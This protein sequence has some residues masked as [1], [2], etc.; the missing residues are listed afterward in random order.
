[1]NLSVALQTPEDIYNALCAIESGYNP[2]KYEIQQIKEIK[3]L[4]LTG[5]GIHE[6][7]SSVGLLSSLQILDLGMTG[8]SSIPEQIGKLISLRKL[9]LFRTK[10]SSLPSSIGN[11]QHL[12]A[13]DLSC[14][15]IEKLPESIC[16]LSALQ[17][18]D[19]SQ[20]LIKELP[21]QIG[22]LSSL[23]RL[24][25]RRTKLS[26]L[27][28]SVI[29]LPISCDVYIN[30]TC[31]ESASVE[32]LN[33][34]RIQRTPK[35]GKVKKQKAIVEKGP[36][37]NN[38]E[39]ITWL[40]LSD[41]H[42]GR[43][44]YNE[45][46]VLDK[47]LDDIQLM[48]DQEAIKLDLILI[49]GDLV[50]S[51]KKEQY[52]IADSFLKKLL[53]VAKL[54]IDDV[55]ITPGNHDVDRS[56]VS[57]NQ[58]KLAR[59]ID[60]RNKVTEIISND[61]T[62]AKYLVGLQNYYSF[63]SQFPWARDA[64][65]LPLHF[66]I[67]KNIRGTQIAVMALNTAWLAY[68]FNNEKGRL[69]LG[70]KQVRDAFEECDDSKLTI[71]LMHHP[72]SWL[73]DF[74]TNDVQNTLERR[75]DFILSGHEH[76]A[77]LTGKDYFLGRA[78]K[79]SAG[80]VY[81]DRNQLN[82]YNIIRC[83]VA[84]GEAECF[85]REYVDKNGGFWTSDNTIDK[86]ITSGK[87]TVKYRVG[88]SDIAASKHDNTKIHSNQGNTDERKAE[89]KE[90]GRY[91]AHTSDPRPSYS[92]PAPPRDLINKIRE[93]K[94]VLFAG[95]GVSMDAGLPG[96][97][98]MLSGMIERVGECY[99]LTSD[100]FT[101]LQKL[102][103][104]GE[105]EIVA[106]YCKDRLGKKDFADYIKKRLRNTG[107]PSMTHSVLSRIPFNAAVTTNYDSLIEDNHSRYKVV[108]PRDLYEKPKYYFRDLFDSEAFPVIK[109]HGSVDDADSLIL[110][111]ADYRN[112]IFQQDRYRD[113]LREIFENKTILFV[114]FSFRDPSISLLLQEIFTMNNGSTCTHYAVLP[115][116]GPIKSDF[117]RRSRNIRVIS[118]PVF[119]GSHHALIELLNRIN[120]ESK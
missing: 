120:E 85:F 114:G 68:G 54:S 12:K 91:W 16:G 119:N 10:I 1:M 56:L 22:N 38:M 81:E 46:V 55:V 59:A 103:D 4:V 24:D 62:R 75:A 33:H 58:K 13:I 28:E 3:K 57:G 77:R 93:G 106:E 87:I 47:L 49:S 29:N 40:H 44:Q 104:S 116:V 111:D 26:Q 83:D 96:W 94:C 15:A 107:K 25:L 117:F 17:V 9:N 73:Q 101:E 52:A 110:T 63:L 50:F 60:S 43:D 65:N 95:A 11:L 48:I 42:I 105:F 21:A 67:N 108:L 109:I 19:L 90:N 23:K 64:K 99:D 69:V 118:Y 14:S 82:S 8:I 20:T 36:E 92:I 18:L 98:E 2:S 32:L 72:F 100:Q 39:E 7:P 76:R 45:N 74:D 102:M 89:A 84:R 112:V 51:G 79:L 35:S 78:F 31:L 80:A 5:L 34:L 86:T 53:S 41:L 97:G 27:P 115:D 71:S 113:N 70:E 6:L 88:D 37:E 30:E 66:T 61:V